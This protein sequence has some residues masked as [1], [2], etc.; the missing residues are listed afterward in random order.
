MGVEVK[1][2]RQVSPALQRTYE[3][4]T[5]AINQKNYR[6]AFEMLRNILVAEPGFNDAR[7]TLRQAQLERVGFASSIG[8]A[9]TAFLKS[10]W[11]MY[12]KGPLQLRKGNIAA[13]LDIGEKAM[14]HDPTLIPTL[15]YMRKMAEAAELPLIAVNCMEIATRFH[16]KSVSVMK[17]LALAY[18]EADQAH[19]AL[20]VWQRLYTLRPNDM[21]VQNELKHATALAAMQT[22]NWEEAE[23][24]RDLIKDRE[25]AENLE[26]ADRISARDEESRLHLIKSILESIEREGAGSDKYRRLADL[27]RQNADYDEAIAAYRKIPEITGTAD[28]AIESIITDVLSDK[29]AEQLASLRERIKAEPDNREAI[30][31][32]VRDLETER[33][34]VL[35]QRFE[36]RVENYPNELRFR[37]ELG[38]MYW[39][40]GRWDDAL[41]EFQQAQRNPQ[42][43]QRSQ[44]FMGKCLR[45]KKLIDL[46]IENITAAL[47]GEQQLPGALRKDALYE[48]GL[49]YEQK[50]D[51]QNALKM[52]KELYGLD[53]NYR[54]VA[55][56]LERYYEQ[57]DQTQQPDA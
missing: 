26:R 33:D 54:D 2:R 22:A 21:Q 27:Y 23:S 44:L 16:P 17:G 15:Q 47:Q 43:A 7:L 42:L 51:S 5:A 41:R 6:Y 4:A 3:R 19:K 8:R 20:G 50:G 29:Y 40:V 13:A 30:E 36:Q 18:K 56:R 45:A 24:Y 55:K 28:P 52:L 53:V 34:R 46:A 11:G 49:L 10:A 12:V 38:E 1:T 31:Q 35:L 48:L 39:K 25:E 37:F 32:Q 57:S 9:F 14:E